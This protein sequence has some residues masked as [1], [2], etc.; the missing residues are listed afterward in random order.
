M[1]GAGHP[2]GA[3]VVQSDL[4]DVCPRMDPTASGLGHDL[5]PM[6][7]GLRSLWP[8]DERNLGA[9]VCGETNL[10][11]NWSG[12]PIAWGHGSKQPALKLC[13]T[14]CLDGTLASMRRRQMEHLDSFN[15]MRTAHTQ[16]WRVGYLQ[17]TGT[18]LVHECILRPVSEAWISNCETPTLRS[19]CSIP[20]GI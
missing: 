19:C 3:H 6:K 10:R 2:E 12:Q 4:T 14:N 15:V 7:L 17:Y 1:F 18:R 13:L 9:G 11:C 20:K 16:R 5:G 8:S